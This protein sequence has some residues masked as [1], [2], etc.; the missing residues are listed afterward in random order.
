MKLLP[1]IILLSS[2]YTCI[3]P[4]KV[5]DSTSFSKLA[6]SDCRFI[7]K[8]GSHKGTAVLEISYKVH[9]EYE[10][11]RGKEGTADL[12]LSL[13]GV[14]QKTHNEIKGLI[15]KKE[16][17][18]FDKISGKLLMDIE[19]ELKEDDTKQF[20]T[21]LKQGL[22]YFYF[23]DKTKGIAKWDQEA[24]KRQKE[25]EKKDEENTISDMAHKLFLRMLQGGSSIE[26][27]IDLVTDGASSYSHHSI[28]E[29]HTL[30][31][32]LSFFFLSL[33][34]MIFLLRKLC[35]YYKSNESIDQPILSITL[36]G[37]FQM[38]GMFFKFL[39][40]YLYSSS[41][42]DMGALEIVSRVFYL[43]ADIVLCSF[44]LLMA[45]GWG[46]VPV[47]IIDQHEIEFVIG[48]FLF[49]LRY[50]W[51]LLGFFLEHGSDEMNHLYDGWTGKL[52]ILNTFVL[53]VW[54]FLSVRSSNALKGQK[55]FENMQT[56][57]KVY[58]TIHLLVRPLLIV[59]VFLFD[60]VDQHLAT[61]FLNHATHLFIC[62]LLGVSFTNKRGVY[63]K[64][65]MSNGLELTGN[66]KIS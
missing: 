23:C 5:S 33:I 9:G 7:T 51:V 52:E 34:F 35:A 46:V 59:L 64:I 11:E 47:D 48:C 38:T 30:E 21:T 8:Y 3:S 31:L 49:C 39:Y 37:A 40:F 24:E 57:L 56:Q 66:T 54:F 26:Y 19:L 22:H 44:F 1:L 29:R 65:S 12:V 14:N 15:E 53:F 42:N 55:K 27:E 4:K 43:M 6:R 2:I 36:S 28:E 62:C 17:D 16:K 13:V 58:G 18:I 10:K 20:W 45:K 63:M 32:T 60:P 61:V 25:N 41:G 50:I